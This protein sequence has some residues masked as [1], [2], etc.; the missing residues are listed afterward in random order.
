MPTL[1]TGTSK[2]GMGIQDLQLFLLGVTGR[3]VRNQVIVTPGITFWRPQ[4]LL[5]FSIGVRPEVQAGSVNAKRVD[6]TN[7]IWLVGVEQAAI[8][9][10]DFHYLPE[11]IRSQIA[12]PTAK[13]PL[14]WQ[15]SHA[16][17]LQAAH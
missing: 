13:L 5:L 7:Q 4:F 15:I 2:E 17:S 11:R 8:A 14:D 10:R 6:G 16:R 12:S 3:L 1:W 9:F